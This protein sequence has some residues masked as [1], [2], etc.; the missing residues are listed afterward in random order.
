MLQKLL[1][2]LKAGPMLCVLLWWLAGWVG[3][4][5]STAPRPPGEGG[6]ILGHWVSQILDGWVS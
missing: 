2:F 5:L 1:K 3:G 6:T 4:W